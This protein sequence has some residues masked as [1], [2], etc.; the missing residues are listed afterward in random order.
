MQTRTNE[1]NCITNMGE[2]LTGENG[3]KNEVT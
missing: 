1:S 3:A 2:N